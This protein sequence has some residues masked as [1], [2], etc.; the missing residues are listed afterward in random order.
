MKRVIRIALVLGIA[1]VAI[2]LTGC[3]DV[4][5]YISGNSS[6]IEVYLRLTLQKSVFELANSMSDEPD[7][8][9]SMFE[10]EFD[11]N[12]NEVL[13]ELPPGVN[14]RF[15]R[16]NSDYEFGFVLSYTAPRELL[17]SVPADEGAFVPR[18]T[19]QGMTIPLGEGGDDGGGDQFVDAF[20]G[21][22]KYRLLISKRL[23]SR[24]SAAR[25]YAGPDSVPVTVIDLPDVWLLEFPVS[26]WFGAAE[27]PSVEILF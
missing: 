12:E 27:S 20:L 10:E 16:V 26:E 22:A 23:V 4:V 8:L 14:A 13:G 24:I 9:D 5:Q 7:D 19:P 21:S 25:L 6:E 1:A 15:E 3:L 17:A 2:G 11:L 18:I